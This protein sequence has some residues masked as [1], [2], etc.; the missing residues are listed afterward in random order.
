MKSF[1]NYRKQIGYKAPCDLFNGQ[2]KKGSIF[3][4]RHTLLSTYSWEESKNPLYFLPAEIVEHWEPVYEREKVFLDSNEFY[5]VTS[6]MDDSG[7]KVFIIHGEKYEAYDI[8]WLEKLMSKYPEIKS[9]N[10]GCEGVQNIKVTKEKLAEIRGLKIE[11]NKNEATV[12]ENAIAWL[13]ALVSG[14][15]KQG[16]YKLGNKKEGFCCW[17]LGCY[18]VEKSYCPQHSWDDNLKGLIGFKTNG[19]LTTPMKISKKNLDKIKNITVLT[20]ISDG[21]TSLAVINDELKIPFKTIGN[22]LIQNANTEFIPEVAE[23]IIK[24]FNKTNF[25]NESI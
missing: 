1:K 11:K 4:L 17:G 16:R 5:E 25:K 22:H 23:N 21:A 6:S 18:I 14:K 13:E 15:Y 3:K 8:E 7:N 9:L 20:A 12:S 2:V 24:H 19:N 10:V